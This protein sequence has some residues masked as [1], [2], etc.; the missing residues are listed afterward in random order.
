VLLD[1]ET[2]WTGIQQAGYQNR[3]IIHCGDCVDGE[4]LPYIHYCVGYVSYSNTYECYTVLDVAYCV[5][6]I[7]WFY[8]SYKRNILMCWFVF[9]QKA[10]Y[11]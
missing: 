8:H 9:L 2:L 11:T 4:G 10:G 7:C 5:L 3:C 6:L 1:A